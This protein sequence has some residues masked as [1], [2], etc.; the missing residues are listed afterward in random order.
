MLDKT[1]AG[2]EVG[3]GKGGSKGNFCITE[4]TE[5]LPVP[6]ESS[7]CL[8]EHTSV[9]LILLISLHSTSGL[10]DGV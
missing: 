4:R 1:C 10:M 9:H 2:E 5:D 6:R 8:K 3:T 7:G